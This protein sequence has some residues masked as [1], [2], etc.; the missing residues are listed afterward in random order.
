MSIHK[1]IQ[2]QSTLEQLI[3]A[4]KT[5]QNK[6]LWSGLLLWNVQPALIEGFQGLYAVRFGRKGYAGQWLPLGVK[7]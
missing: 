1:G 3:V 5:K 6:N 7:R 4:N 2:P